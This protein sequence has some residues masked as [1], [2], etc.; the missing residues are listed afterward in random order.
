MVKAWLKTKFS[1]VSIYKLKIDQFG[2]FFIFNILFVQRVVFRKRSILTLRR[3]NTLYAI[4]LPTSFFFL[5]QCTNRAFYFLILF[6]GL[7]SIGKIRINQITLFWALLVAQNI[8][9]NKKSHSLFNNSGT[10]NKASI[11]V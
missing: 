6:F 7:D 2:F 3:T 9:N 8:I 1:K 4:C 5:F 10:I 11:E